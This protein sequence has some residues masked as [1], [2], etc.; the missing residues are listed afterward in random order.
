MAEIRQGYL[1]QAAFLGQLQTGFSH[2][3]GSGSMRLFCERT[4]LTAQAKLIPL[5][6]VAEDGL[7][8][9]VEV[10]DVWQEEDC[11]DFVKEI[12]LPQ[13]WGGKY[14]LPITEARSAPL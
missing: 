8:F 12:V 4:Q 11:N 14:A 5:A 2:C 6:L 7:E 9:Y 1:L 3:R 10:I 13:L